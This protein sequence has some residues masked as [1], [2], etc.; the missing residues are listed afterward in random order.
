MIIA[1]PVKAVGVKI[2]SFVDSTSANAGVEMTV[3][4][5]NIST[6]AITSSDVSGESNAALTA[7]SSVQNFQAVQPLL[8][9]K[10][11]SLDQTG[12]N[13]AGLQ[14]VDDLFSFATFRSHYKFEESFRKL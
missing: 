8:T 7:A 11:Q 14:S 4:Q 10:N 5:S 13:S 12:V 9:M 3:S 6:N 1:D 2:I